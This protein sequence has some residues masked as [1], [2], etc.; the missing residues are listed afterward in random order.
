ML[1]GL[2]LDFQTEAV[3]LAMLKAP[4]AKPHD[5]ALS[6]RLA[7]RQVHDALDELARISLLQ[8]STRDPLTLRPVHP[9]AAL[10]ALVARRQAEFARLQQEL[11]EGKAAVAVLLAE[12]AELNPPVR[13]PDV[14]YVEGA[15]AV[16]ARLRELTNA[17]RWEV[18]AFVPAHSQLPLASDAS[19]ASGEPQARAIERGVRYRTVFLDSIRNHQPALEHAQWLVALGTEVRTAPLL[20]L[21]LFIIDR[22]HALV[23][24]DPGGASD[25]AAMVSSAGMVTALLAL[26]QATWNG[27]AP[28]GGPRRRDGDGLTPQR[29][30]VLRLLA[31]GCTDDVIARRLGVSIR[32]ARRVASD[33]LSRLDARSRFQAGARAVA[34]GWLDVDDLD[35]C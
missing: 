30:Q 27:A 12:H 35:M 5:L 11:E 9:E 10:Q 3:Y 33:L 34:C 7:E 31:T 13:A 1:E 23:P 26:F 6:L 24:V 32:T 19:D 29:R 8:P 17:S 21:Q 25:A 28:L 18:C 14:E 16:E 22:A 15:D 20:P 4:T 2:G